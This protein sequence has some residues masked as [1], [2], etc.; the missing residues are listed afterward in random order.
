MALPFLKMQGLGND[1]I[2]IDD[3]GKPSST[4]NSVTAEFARKICDRRYGIGADQL[5]WLR[6]AESK[7]ADVRMEVL[8]SDGSVAEMC[9]NG[10]RAVGHYL[11]RYGLR[12]HQANYVVETLA[13][14]K[15]VEVR[16]SAIAVHMGVPEVSQ[17]ESLAING[18]NYDFLP[19]NMGNPHAVIFVSDVKSV[20]LETVGP[21]I[22]RH[23]RF[24][25][26]TN[27]EFVQVLSDHEIQ[28]RIWERGAGATLACGTGACAAA[29]AAF[30]QGKIKGVVQVKLPGGDLKINWDGPGK[31]VVMEGPAQ[32]V[33][34][35]EYFG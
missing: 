16:A 2:V 26:R 18:T 21:L 35:G 22:E 24:P 17:S 33:F 13:G 23:S 25:A 8:N 3:L 4:F 19:V 29:V 31:S 20:A 7:D 12:P 34:R 27:V 11:H 5:L 30:A 10:V 32:E 9:G 1:V 28:V 6:D 14:L 15:P